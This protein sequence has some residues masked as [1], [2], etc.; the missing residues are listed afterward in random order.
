MY[1]YPFDEINILATLQNKELLR[2]WCSSGKM[3]QVINDCNSSFKCCQHAA[4]MDATATKF[5]VECRPTS[6]NVCRLRALAL[7]ATVLFPA[8]KSGRVVKTNTSA[9]ST[10]WPR[11]HRTPEFCIYFI[12]PAVY[13]S[14]GLVWAPSLSR[15]AQSVI[16]CH[17]LC[18]IFRGTLLKRRRHQ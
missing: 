12:I 7:T 5:T 1:R 13:G 11:C 2:W 18:D 3:W 17:V 15:P 6:E 14:S 4:G 8:C 9:S 10:E 16:R